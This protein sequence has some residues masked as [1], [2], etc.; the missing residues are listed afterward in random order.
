MKISL[1]VA[2]ASLFLGILTLAPASAL[3]S[4][5]PRGPSAH[6][7]RYHDRTPTVHSRSAHPHHG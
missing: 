7:V 6:T 1:Q 5:T 3:A 4:T 2:L